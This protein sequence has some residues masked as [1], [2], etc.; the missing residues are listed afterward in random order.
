MAVGISGVIPANFT[1]SSISLNIVILTT[2]C[3]ANVCG[4]RVSSNIIVRLESDYKLFRM[5][6]LGW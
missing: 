5:Q 4:L 3:F 2:D 1:V 6:L